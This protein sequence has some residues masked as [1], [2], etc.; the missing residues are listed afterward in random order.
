MKDELKN[1]VTTPEFDI[2]KLA[3]DAEEQEIAKAMQETQNEAMQETQNE[4][5]EDYDAEVSVVDGATKIEPTD[6]EMEELKNPSDFDED[7]LEYS[8][9]A[10][11]FENRESQWDTYRV[12][13]QYF[14]PEESVLDFGCARGDFEKFYEGEYQ[15]TIDYTGIDFNQQLIDAGNKVYDSEVELVCSDWFNIEESM[16]ADWCIN[17]N[18][19][20]LRYDADTTKSD[21]EYLHATIKK[22]MAHCEKGSIIL[23]ASDSTKTDDGLTNWS[24]SALLDWSMKTFGSVAIDH[25]FSDDIFTLIIYKN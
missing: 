8:A 24:A 22:M 6:E 4:T 9:E 1:K 12:V 11:G 18:S 7:Y 13:S 14:A 17:I 25:S 16:K 15:A 2:S 10:V 20:N 19:S 23:L 21:E 3:V 5:T